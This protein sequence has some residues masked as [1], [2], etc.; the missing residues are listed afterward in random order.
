MKKLDIN[1]VLQGIQ[2]ILLVIIGYLIFSSNSNLK[3]MTLELDRAK[4][5]L[6]SAEDSIINI[7]TKLKQSNTALERVYLEKDI[8]IR[9]R[10]SLLFDFKRKNTKNKNI[11]S[12]IKDSI[13]LNNQKLK[14]DKILLD[15]LFDIK[16]P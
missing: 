4:K 6:E 2:L 16:A 14:E 5:E 10:D 13:I 1:T 3:T 8:I 12:A 7:R 15:K 9:Q 11:L